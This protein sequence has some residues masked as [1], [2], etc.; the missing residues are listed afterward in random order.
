MVFR[1]IAKFNFER[2]SFQMFLSDKNKVAFLRIENNSYHYPTMKEFENLMY[3]FGIFHGNY[4][5]FRDSRHTKYSFIPFATMSI[6]GTV[7]KVMLTSLLVMSLLVGCGSTNNAK[8]YSY[9]YEPLD[10]DYST[11]NDYI[12]SDCNN[13]AFY[14]TEDF[15]LLESSKMVTLYNNKYFDQL[16][17]CENVSVEETI[18]SARLNSKIPDNFRTSIE[19]FIYTMGN[20]YKSLDFRVYNHNIKTLEFETKSTD[21][22]DF[23]MGGAVAM[24]DFINN[25]MLISE[26]LDLN[27]PK[28]RLIFRHELGHLFNHLRMTKDGYEIKY[29]FDDAS[30]GTYLKEALDVILTTNPF[31]DEY[32]DDEIT[33]NMGYP[34]TTNIVRVL[35]EC[36]NYNIESSVSNNVYNFQNILNTA[37]PDDIDAAVIEELIEIQWIEYSSALIQVNDEDY[38]DLYGYVARAYIKKYINSQMTYEEIK[39]IQYELE[40]R[41]LLGVKEEKYVYTD[42]I[43][44]EFDN[45]IEENNITKLS[46]LTM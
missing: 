29:S 24:Y 45:Y 32:T 23:V 2:K 36:S 3:L 46:K 19:D 12:N 41:L 35:V 5:Y 30:R 42:T 43:E 26:N 44:E 8:T 38:K 27:D 34:I 20:S 10:I 15:E 33:K 31:M 17:G 13:S 25:K 7:R 39:D 4:A 18:E 16:F 6:G 14:E 1:K 40:A 28:S 21:D 22:V 11:T 9:G 37:F